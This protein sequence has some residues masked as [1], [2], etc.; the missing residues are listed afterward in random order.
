MPAKTKRAIRTDVMG[1]MAEFSKPMQAAQSRQSMTRGALH[2]AR[3][4]FVPRG[5]AFKNGHSDGAFGERLSFVAGSA[6][7]A[8]KPRK[9]VSHNAV[10]IAATPRRC[11]AP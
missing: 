5:T 3:E 10:C 4:P 11:R 6:S 1:V 9:T 2:V 7:A 8:I